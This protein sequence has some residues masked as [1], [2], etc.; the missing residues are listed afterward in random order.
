MFEQTFCPIRQWPTL[1]FDKKRALV[2]DE[3]VRNWS[4]EKYKQL[5][6]I[7]ISFVTYHDS[8]PA[9]YAALEKLVQELRREE[10]QAGGDIDRSVFSTGWGAMEFMK[11]CNF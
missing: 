7:P 9:H 6:K 4:P 1:V 10:D 11:V 2:I 8:E 3:L 5:V